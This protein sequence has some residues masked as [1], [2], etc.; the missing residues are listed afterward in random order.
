MGRDLIVHHHGALVKGRNLRNAWVQIHLWLGLTFGVGGVLIGVTGSILVFDHDI[1]AVLNPKRYAVTGSQAAL[2]PSDYLKRSSEAVK[3]RA[4]PVNL[5]FPAAAGMPIVVLMRAPHGNAAGFQRVY[6][7]PPTGRVL[8][9]ETGRGFIGTAHVL[10]ENLMLREY[11]GRELVGAIGF[12]MLISSLSGIYLWWPLHGK[13]GGVFGFRDGFALT[14]NLHYTFGFYAS[15][16]LAALSFTGIYLALPDAGRAVVSV[17]TALSP[18]L[19]GVQA[20]ESSGRPMAADEA[21][22]IVRKLYPTATVASIGL[23]SGPRGAYRASLR[24]PGDRSER[25]STVIF[26]DPRTREVLRRAD[27]STQTGGD[28]FL[29]WQRFVHTGEGLNIVWRMLICIVGLL[30]GL[31]VV[32]GT[33]MWLRQRRRAAVARTALPATSDV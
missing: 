24:E 6:L 8:D 27:R 33:T 12:A 13:W 2:P 3:D 26:V 31:L 30:P 4:R 29:A 9:V 32:T 16:V 11:W 20:P 14:R 17:F 10:H 1:D 5:R 15:L 22:D 25:G 23:P 19:R 28:M 7:D 21:L 18:S